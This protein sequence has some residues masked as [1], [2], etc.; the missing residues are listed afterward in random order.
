V[1]EKDA[2]V[3]LLGFGGVPVNVGAASGGAAPEM[4]TAIAA[5]AR[6]PSTARSFVLAVLAVL[7]NFT[8]MS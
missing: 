2:L 5:T 3:E 7:R 1:N 4:A 6:T 8:L